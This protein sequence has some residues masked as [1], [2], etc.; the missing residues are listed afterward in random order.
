MDYVNAEVLSGLERGEVVSTGET[1]SSSSS[2]QPSTGTEAP[3]AGGN[4]MRFL[5]G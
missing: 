1:T 3:P 4:M 5:G 2:S